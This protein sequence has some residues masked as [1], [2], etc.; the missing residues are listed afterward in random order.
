MGWDWVATREH[1]VMYEKSWFN[2]KP[3]SFLLFGM[4]AAAS[5]A[6]AAPTPPPPPPPPKIGPSPPPPPRLPTAVA[7]PEIDLGVA[8]SAL[9]FL[10][11]AVAIVRGRRR[12]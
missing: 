1:V 5:T 11:G 10:A 12:A 8:G 7:A 9:I 3:A 4:L 2:M 6:L